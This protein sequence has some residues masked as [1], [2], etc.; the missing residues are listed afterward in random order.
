MSFFIYIMKQISHAFYIVRY[1]RAY[2]VEYMVYRNTRNIALHQFKH[3][4]MVK[5]GIRNN[6]TV[7]T[8]VPA[9][10]QIGHF[11]R[12]YAAAVKESNIIPFVFRRTFQT[13]QH[14]CKI[15]MRQT[16]VVIYRKQNADV[17]TSFCLKRF[18]CGIRK[19]SHFFGNSSDI[20]FC[21]HTN[22]LVVIERLAYGR[23]RYSALRRNVFH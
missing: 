21:L 9:M 8:S 7:K 18:R 15:I 3:F 5:L 2:I 13:V 19:I 20:C 6:D 23:D 16:A 14:L 11:I 22:V 10:L 4:R 12:S 17:I 1:D